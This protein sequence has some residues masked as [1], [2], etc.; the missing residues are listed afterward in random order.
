MVS[1]VPVAVTGMSTVCF[2]A[3]MVLAL[4]AVPARGMFMM[5]MPIVTHGSFVACVMIRV[6]GGGLSRLGLVVSRMAVGV[7]VSVVVA[8][9]HAGFLSVEVIMKCCRARRSGRYQSSV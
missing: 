4:L 9:N 8:F 1:V 6:G 2:V 3:G 7:V 5:L